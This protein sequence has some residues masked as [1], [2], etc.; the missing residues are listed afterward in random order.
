MRGIITG[1]KRVEDHN[2]ED[3]SENENEKECGMEESLSLDDQ[4]RLME[5]LVDLEQ[6]NLQ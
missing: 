3:H 4:K 1:S 2:D 5:R 6:R